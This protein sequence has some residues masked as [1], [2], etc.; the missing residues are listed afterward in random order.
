MMVASRSIGN[1]QPIDPYLVYI[2]DIKEPESKIKVASE[3]SI[4]E[5]EGETFSLNLI[6]EILLNL[7]LLN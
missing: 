5:I 7:A 2:S 3:L 1:F 4:F 6:K